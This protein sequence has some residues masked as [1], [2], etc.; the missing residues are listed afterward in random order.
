MVN[1]DVFTVDGNESRA[2]IWRRVLR[3][4]TMTSYN[5]NCTNTNLPA[6]TVYVLHQN[7]GILIVIRRGKIKESKV[8]CEVLSVVIYCVFTRRSFFK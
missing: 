4:E 6:P 7:L 2:H 8:I 1:V 5:M 3:D